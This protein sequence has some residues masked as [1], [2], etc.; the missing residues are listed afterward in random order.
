MPRPMRAAAALCVLALAAGPA[1]GAA[2]QQSAASGVV[3][4]LEQTGLTF[5]KAS[6]AIWVVSFKSS[7]STVVDVIVNAQN[8]LVVVFAVV[9]RKPAL[10]PEQLRDLLRANYEAN[11]AKLAIDHDGDLLAL[12]ELAP[13]ILT[14]PMLRTA[15]EEVANAGDSAAH[16]VRG[17]AP[18]EE[19]VEAIASGRGG[20]LPLVRGAFEL[21]YDPAK[22]KP[23]PGADPAVV[24]VV[25]ASG[26]AFLRI[27]T[28][29][30]EVARPH[31]SEVSL[32]S[33]R[34]TSPDV[35]VAS[36]SWRT[37]NGLHTLLLR[38]DGVVNGNRYSYYSQAY[39]DDAGTVQIVVWTGSNL[40]DEYRQD[41][42]EL[43]AGFR[44]VTRR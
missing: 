12:A 24:E 18:S 2:A 7:S 5:R 6:D 15:I 14:A 43:L 28:Q 16:L 13:R 4:A 32:T 36:E 21:A 29:R 9:A 35:R 26:E 1:A 30:V 44:K 39:S 23:K 41:F 22:W 37:V 17:P 10:S 8:E 33:A 25:H 42:L 34:R 27:I 38:L 19:H 31:W 40:F 11:F 20:S 3:T